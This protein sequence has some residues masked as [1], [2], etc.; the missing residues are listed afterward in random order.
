MKFIHNDKVSL[1]WAILVEIAVHALFAFQAFLLGGFLGEI[2]LTAIF[3]PG[4]GPKIGAWALAVFVF[5]A[6]MQ[7][8]V[9]GEYMKEHVQ[10][11]ER[12]GKDGSYIRSFKQVRGLVFGIEITSLLFRIIVVWQAGDAL[13]A[14][15]VALFGIVTLWYAYAQ[16]KVIHASV[17]RPIE[18]HVMQAQHEVGRSFI[19]D[20]LKRKD[21]MTAEEKARFAGGDFAAITDAARTGFFADEQRRQAKTSRSQSRQTRRLEE[22]QHEENAREQQEH[23]KQAAGGLFNPANWGKSTTATP[24]NISN[25]EEALSSSQANHQ[26]RRQQ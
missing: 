5:G 6:A 4:L 21:E 7:A 20:I 19:D 22:Q 18:Y 11:Y 25:F 14:F 3:G 12:T 24:K 1:G 2:A 17:N 15:V 16:A 9:L 26:S 23:T 8:F 10:S 13:Q